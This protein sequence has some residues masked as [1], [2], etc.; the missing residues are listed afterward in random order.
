MNVPDQSGPIPGPAPEPGPALP[1]QRQQFGW[2]FWVLLLTLLVGITVVA[3][4]YRVTTR[5]TAC[6]NSCIA[7][8]KQIDGAVQQWALENKK[9]G[10]AAVTTSDILDFLKG[11]VLPLCPAH[12]TFSVSTVSEAPHC[13][14]SAIGH[15]L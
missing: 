13:T 15:S 4:P 14:Q 7:N 2:P 8:L 1:K 11:S 9:A 3:L 6:K 5:T 12:G 10:T